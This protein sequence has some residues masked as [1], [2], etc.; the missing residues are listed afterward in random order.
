MTFSFA[1]FGTYLCFIYLLD[2]G[3][4]EPTIT[5][6]LMLFL[7]LLGIGF[8]YSI[9]LYLIRGLFLYLRSVLTRG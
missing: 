5:Q 2:P 7:C 1:I 6:A 8:I 3:E 9:V 4:G